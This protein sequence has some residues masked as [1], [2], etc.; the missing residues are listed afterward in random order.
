MRIFK[1]GH[2]IAD[3]I[4]D[5]VGDLPDMDCTVAYGILRG[6]R[7]EFAKAA[8]WF[9]IDRGYYDPGHFDGNYRLS[10]RDMQAI[11]HDGIP[12]EP[13][14]VELDDWRDPDSGYTLICPPTAAVCTFYG[15]S[16]IDW[17]W[18]AVKR[19]NGSPYRIRE[20]GTAD[21][22]AWDEVG[23]VITFNSGVAWQAVQ[24]GIQT[25]SDPDHSLVGSFTKAKKVLD[26]YDRTELFNIIG[27]HQ[28]KLGDKEKICRILQHYR[29]S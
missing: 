19:C 11:Y 24:R 15:I 14:S 26:G 22:L 12:S 13:Y 29:F 8:N 23:R 25:I 2:Q 20:K 7:E 6:T 1:T 17:V 21:P 5:I 10:Y 9:E 16:H 27:F 3:I 4:S 28:F 18:G